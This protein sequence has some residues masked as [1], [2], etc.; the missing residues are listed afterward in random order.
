MSD[1]THYEVMVILKPDLNQKQSKEALDRM[2]THITS[3][4]GKILHEDIWGKKEFA[5][6]M[7][8]FNEGFYAIFYFEMEEDKTLELRAELGLDQT[9]IREMI[10]KFPKKLAFADYLQKEKEINV[11]LEKEEEEKQKKREEAERKRLARRGIKPK[12]DE[13]KEEKKD[14][15]KEKST[16]E[17]K[18]EMKEDLDKMLGKV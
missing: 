11:E 1:M 13:D 16:E 6:T 8:K 3:Q 4:G 9:V 2:R 10:T 18:D 17:K 5:Y 12:K 15:K 7:K 14:D